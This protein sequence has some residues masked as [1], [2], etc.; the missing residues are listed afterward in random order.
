MRAV[1]WVAAVLVLAQAAGAVAFLTQGV[2]LV[3]AVLLVGAATLILVWLRLRL[4]A[5]R[6]EA[7]VGYVE[8]EFTGF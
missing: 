4:A 6:P 3:A 2:W 7:M 1:P 8:R 5:R